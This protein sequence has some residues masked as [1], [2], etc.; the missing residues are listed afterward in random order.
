MGTWH[1]QIQEFC[2]TDVLDVC[3]TYYQMIEVYS[4]GAKTENGIT[5]MGETPEELINELE[6]MIAD[7]KKYPHLTKADKE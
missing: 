6:R 5:P 1:Y 2:Y 7:A 3:H 4:S